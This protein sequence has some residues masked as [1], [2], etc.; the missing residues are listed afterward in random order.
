MAGGGLGVPANLGERAG[1]GL[2][3]P[4]N[5]GER[6]GAGSLGVDAGLVES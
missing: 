3:V 1:G 6:A 5:Q 4:T 2:S